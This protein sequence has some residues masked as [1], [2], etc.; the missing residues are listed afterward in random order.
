MLL[1]RGGVPSV[2]ASETHTAFIY[3]GDD[4]SDDRERR[5]L[6]DMSSGKVDRTWGLVC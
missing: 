2:R 1:G 5:D 6:K 3:L 4:G